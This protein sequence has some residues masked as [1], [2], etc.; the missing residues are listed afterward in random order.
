MELMYVYYGTHST[1]VS[2]VDGT[3]TAPVEGGQAKGG[4]ARVDAL[5]AHI[6]II[7]LAIIRMH[8]NSINA[9]R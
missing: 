5:H 3:M 8:I 4:M 2:R 7:P 1:F 9:F 6:I